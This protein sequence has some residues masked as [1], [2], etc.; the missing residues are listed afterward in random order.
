MF[1]N[2]LSAIGNNEYPLFLSF[3]GF[4]LFIGTFMDAIPA[5]VLFVTS[6]LSVRLTLESILFS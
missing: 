4:F 5:M 3:C 1:A 2:S 6:D